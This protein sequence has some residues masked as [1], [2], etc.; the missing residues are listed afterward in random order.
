MKKIGIHCGL[1][2][3]AALLA[4]CAT[5]DAAPPNFPDM[6]TP[7]GGTITNHLDAALLQP[8]TE[9]SVLGAGDQLD[10]EMTGNAASRASVV[11]VL[12]G[13]IYYSLLP[14]I[15]VMGLTLDEA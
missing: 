11:V 4:G 12:D 7:S 3:V 6:A 13:K 8:S 1:A 14:G 15:N 5:P 9:L 2:L 10:I